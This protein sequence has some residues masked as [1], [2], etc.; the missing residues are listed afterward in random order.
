MSTT[1]KPFVRLSSDF[2]SSLGFLWLIRGEFIRFF[3][4]IFL[5]RDHTLK[6]W[7]KLLKTGPNWNVWIKTREEVQRS[8][9]SGIF[10][11]IN[12]EEGAFSCDS[13]SVLNLKIP[14][15][16]NTLITFRSSPNLHIAVNQL[17][18]NISANK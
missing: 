11:L 12:A 1:R 10:K 3:Y 7:K 18:S 5:R 16:F 8:K 2:A 4:Q 15:C 9:L 17:F 14:D 6:P 13:K